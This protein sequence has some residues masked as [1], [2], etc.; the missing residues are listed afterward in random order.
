MGKGVLK[1]ISCY[2]Q[3]KPDLDVD[4][5]NMMFAKNIQ[6]RFVNG[7]PNAEKRCLENQKK[8]RKYQGKYKHYIQYKPKFH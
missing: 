5:C 4:I 6:V 7:Q 3:N 2:I 8:K 1:M